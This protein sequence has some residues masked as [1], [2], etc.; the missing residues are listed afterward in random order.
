MSFEDLLREYSQCSGDTLLYTVV[1][2][3]QVK[4]HEVAWLKVRAHEAVEPTWMLRCECYFTEGVGWK[5]N[6]LGMRVSLIGPGYP[7]TLYAMKQKHAELQRE[8]AHF[9]ER[10]RIVRLVTQAVQ[11]VRWRGWSA[12]WI[13]H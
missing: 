12:G 13:W 7:H 9:P 5:R 11:R 1:W 2:S 4:G 3:I 6:D 8:L 10:E